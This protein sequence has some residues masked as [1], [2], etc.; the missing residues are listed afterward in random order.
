V[1]ALVKAEPR[2]EAGVALRASLDKG[3]ARRRRGEAVGT[4]E[5]LR[6]VEPRNWTFKMRRAEANEEVA[7]RVPSR[8]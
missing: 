5:W 2:L 8:G 3:C 4:E 1:L 7:W 6:R